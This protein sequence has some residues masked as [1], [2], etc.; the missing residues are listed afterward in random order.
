MGTYENDDEHGRDRAWRLALAPTHFLGMGLWLIWI[1][2]V[3]NPTLLFGLDPT[4]SSYLLWTRAKMLLRASALGTFAVCMSVYRTPKNPRRYRAVLTGGTAASVIGSLGLGLILHNDGLNLDLLAYA[5]TVAVGAGAVVLFL[6]WSVAYAGL[7]RHL[8]VQTSALTMLRSMAREGTGRAATHTEGSCGPHEAA[9]H[10]ATL[11]NAISERLDVGT[12]LDRVRSGFPWRLVAM[13]GWVSFACGF[14]PADPSVSEDGGVALW[15]PAFLY[16]IS[17][18]L[19]LPV[20]AITSQR[21][22][23]SAVIAFGLTG[24]TV[25]LMRVFGACSRLLVLAHPFGPPALLDTLPVALSICFTGL[26]VFRLVDGREGR[27][28]MPEPPEPTVPLKFTA[29]TTPYRPQPNFTRRESEVVE[30]L[31]DGLTYQQ[32]SEELT[33]T[34][35]TV[36]THV[37]HVYRKLGVTNRNDAVSIVIGERQAREQAGEPVA[38]PACLKDP[39]PADREGSCPDAYR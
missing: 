23:S 9:A 36:K 6:G 33:V 15:L 34:M 7:P 17:W 35:S 37:H 22:G 26:I 30:A 3:A 5:S 20:L 14:N 38:D 32:I 24:A 39:N 27:P 29:T 18:C 2:G 8:L 19:I 11:A 21:D 4:S 1:W 25:E 16:G 28:Q 13:L 12:P 10:P 31:I